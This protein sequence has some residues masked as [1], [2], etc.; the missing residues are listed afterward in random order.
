MHLLIRTRWLG[1]V[2]TLWSL[3][4]LFGCSGVSKEAR[5]QVSYT[6]TFAELQANPEPHIGQTVL[7]GGNIISVQVLG[8]GS[9]LTV[10]QLELGSSDRPLD[11]DASQG[12]FL[13]RSARFLDPALYPEKT[14]IT[15]V[16]KVTGIQ[17]RTI[18]DMPYR[19]PVLEPVEIKKWPIESA[20]SSPSFHF[21][22]GVGK[23]F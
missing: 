12:R 22:I 20:P 4:W 19:Y 13:I 17:E 5:S 14:P 15:V 16:G 23:T 1:A 21:G 10:L 18:G 2:L 7:L 9:E 3:G 8:Q 11:T 6:G